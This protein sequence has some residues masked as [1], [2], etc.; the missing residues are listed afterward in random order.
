MFENK[1]N[2]AQL[3]KK[4]TPLIRGQVFL[5]HWCPLNGERTVVSIY[6]FFSEGHM[7]QVEI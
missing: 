2:I 6:L 7:H 1:T 5:H 4:R 3:S